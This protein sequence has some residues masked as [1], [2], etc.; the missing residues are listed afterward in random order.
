MWDDGKGKEEDNN[1]KKS[2]LSNPQWALSVVELVRSKRI[3]SFYILLR[4]IDSVAYKLS[5]SRLVESL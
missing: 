1:K 5:S 3:K 2:V 4:A